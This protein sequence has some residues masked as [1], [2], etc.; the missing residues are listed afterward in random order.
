MSLM[1]K[2]YLL[3]PYVEVD[4]GLKL[5]SRIDF[6]N[7]LLCLDYTLSAD[8]SKLQVKLPKFEKA[9]R[10]DE[11][12]KS[13]CFEAFLFF[14]EP[15]YLEINIS[16]SGAWNTYSFSSYRKDMVMTEDL[17]LT[18]LSSSH[19]DHE[20]HLEACFDYNI[21]KYPYSIQLCAVLKDIKTGVLNYWALEHD[22]KNPDFH[23]KR[24]STNYRWS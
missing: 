7:G 4:K 19:S 16:P 8:S 20:F 18:H 13:T 3:K 14:N 15:D 12:W 17:N 5:E 11:L 6:K 23:L 9:Q 24:L 10:Q 21:K 1:G 2:S 22:N